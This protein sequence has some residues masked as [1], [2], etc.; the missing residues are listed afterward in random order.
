MEIRRLK[1][2]FF[3]FSFLLFFLATGLG[4]EGNRLSLI[5]YLQQLEQE[6]NVKFSYVDEDLTDI[7]ID[8]PDGSDLSLIL[9]TLEELTRLRIEKLSD[10]YYSIVLSTTVDICGFVFD[11]YG[12]NTIPGASVEVLGSSTALVT[13]MDGRF[14]LTN[15][16]RDANLR[17]RFLGFKPRYIAASELSGNDCPSLLMALS[18]QELQEVV[19][20]QFLTTGL[21]RETDGS[22]LL[23]TEDFGILPGLSEPDILQTVQALPGIKSIDETVSDINIRGGTNDQNL[24]LWDGI[25]MYQ[26]GHF[27]GLISAFNP[28]LT[29][30]V[31]VIKNGTSAQYGDGVSGI[32][33]METRDEVQDRISGGGGF[34]LI[35]GDLYGHVPLSDR[36]AL[37]F[38]G[39]RSVTDFLNTP[40]YNQFFDRAFQDT[41]VK[42]GGGADEAIDRDEN[43][44]FYDFTGKLLYDINEDHKL[45]VSAIYI[46]NTL[47]YLES[48]QNT[49]RSDQSLLDQ[50]NFSLGGRLASRWSDRFSTQI[51]AYLTRYNLDARNITANG[52]QSLFQNNQ[53]LESS[54]KVNT[55]Y[56]LT[57]QFHFRNGYQFTEVGITNFTNVTQPPFNSNIKGVIRMHALFSELEYGSEDGK[58]DVIGGARLNYIENLG[59]FEEIILE[60]RLNM[61]Y[62]LWPDFRFEIQGEFK[63]Q[64]TNQVVD[65][66]QNFLGIEKRRW[67][68]SDEDILPVTRS[69]QGSVGFNYDKNRWFIGLEG[70]FKEVKGISTSTQGFQN[71]DQFDGEIGS[72]TIRGAEFLVNYKN[73]RFSSWASYAYN[74]NTYYFE[75]ITPSEFPNNLDITHTATLA[76]TYNYRDLKLGFGLNYRTGKPFTKPREGNSPIDITV[77][78]N[79][80]IYESPNSSRLPDYLRADA[81]LIYSFDLDSKIRATAGISVLN[82]FGKRNVLNTYYRLNDQNE[83]ETVESISLGLTPNASFRVSF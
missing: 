60:P 67:I 41:E 23:S 53:V 26:S 75:D 69:K 35:S 9:E 6:F 33:S 71:E 24:I 40:T 73:N 61:S 14:T 20:Y 22:I 30:K 66:E 13:D 36:I 45:R 81:S 79:R 42:G 49:G 50:T 62:M 68:L 11:N 51:S 70:F 43:F 55:R 59:T 28:Y 52:E 3:C 64:V 16:P 54:F 17:I 80:I 34:N 25:K 5:S 74:K 31:T 8:P 63:N 37:Q 29:E 39:R 38:S 46:N 2:F 10:R 15:V 58:L 77:F 1:R 7:E 44:Y 47:D 56:T 21:T 27:F 78:P 12:K 18:Y 19:V 76:T 32:I 65:L 72:Y 83:I 82:I 4:Q 48:N 57:D